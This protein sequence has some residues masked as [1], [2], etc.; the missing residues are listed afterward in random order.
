MAGALPPGAAAKLERAALWIAVAI[1]FSLPIST[2][3]DGLL[4]VALIVCWIASG[5]W[6]ERVSVL[7]HNAFVLFPSALFLLY[8]A[9]SSYSLGDP[10][11]VWN[12]VGKAST[13][14]L[15]PILISLRPGPEWCNRA[16][17]AFAAAML[18]TLALSFLV[19]WRILPEAEFIKGTPYD[20]VVF[21]LRIT[22]GVFMAFAA[23]LFA[24]FARDSRQAGWRW[25][26]AALALLATFNVLFMV[27]GRTG[28][29][30]LVVLLV[31]FLIASLRWR[32]MLAAL[33]A[34]FVAIGA[35][36]HYMPSSSLY[37]RAQTTIKEFENWR[38]GR[39]ITPA[40]M[41]FETWRNS[42]ELVQRHPL[43]G[44]GTGSFATAYARQV[45]GT[46]MGAASQPENQYLLTAVQ[47]GALGVAAL[48]AMF[49]AQ[50]HLAAGLATR[51]DTDFTRGLVIFMVVGCLFNSFLL[52]HAEALF[53]AWLSGLLFARLQHAKRRMHEELSSQ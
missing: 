20:A 39:P 34:A 14:L 33:A 30:M 44:T 53:Y 25:L 50:W 43:L 49:A 5:S 47:L 9:G 26:F 37:Q 21:K 13:L 52:D 15:I 16:L 38:A 4:E 32:A 12:A 40:N 6:G 41:R 1:G 8:V 46:S 29:L 35:A 10:E 22:H 3:L 36:Y 31:H 48:L 45:A 27:R 24:G 19:W 17:Q 2:A 23:Y 11:D 7:R 28:Q 42:L 51:T 18:L